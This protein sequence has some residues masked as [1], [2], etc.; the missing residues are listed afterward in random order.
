MPKIVSYRKHITTAITRELRLPEENGQRVGQEIATV[1]GITYVSLP[2]GVALPADQPAEI[3]SSIVDPVTL[4]ADLRKAIKSASPHVELINRRIAEKIAERY[5]V[6][7]EIKLIRTAPSA[8]FDAYNT[9]V[10]ECRAWGRAQKAALG[11]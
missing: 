8:E 9:Y 2:D 10:E 3:A 5:S 7:D 4:T 6:H 11:L 1:D